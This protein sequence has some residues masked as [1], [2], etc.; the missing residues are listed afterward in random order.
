MKQKT[1]LIVIVFFF[2]TA[3][4]KEPIIEFYEPEFEVFVLLPVEGIGDRGFI[5]II[6]EG[7]ETAFLDY[8]F[9]VN[10]IIPENLEKADVWI[11]NLANIESSRALNTLVIIAG[12]QYVKALEALGGDFGS[13]KVLF[14]NGSFEENERLASM[15]YRSY[16]PSYI[17]G[18]LS[19]QL[20][21]NCRA[22][23]IAGFDAPFYID[24]EEGF[25]QGVIDAGGSFYEPAYI[26]NDFS[27]FAMAD[28][29]YRLT[30]ELLDRNDLILALANGSNSGIINAARDYPEQRYV[31]GIESDQSWMGLSVVTGSV[32]SLIGTDIYNYIQAFSQGNFDYGDFV[33]TMEDGSTSFLINEAVMGE[34]GIPENLIEIAIQKEKEYLLK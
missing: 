10:Y 21:P 19:T 27:G 14:I 1:Y 8:E 30:K 18:Y 4:S 12:A 26:S 22:M 24:Y 16:A 7:V 2:L 17:G 13:H 34:G 6:Y 20:I 32:I 31:I 15:I 5:D 29:A 23:V 33:R 11:K 25:K 3:C 9:R 28:S